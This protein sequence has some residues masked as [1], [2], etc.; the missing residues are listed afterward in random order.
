MA[1]LLAK[2]RLDISGLCLFGFLDGS[3]G[4]FFYI[5]NTFAFVVTAKC[6]SAMWAQ[7]FFALWAWVE[8]CF[9]QGKMRGASAFV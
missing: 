4:A 8:S 2:W 1:I 3:V 9:C 5:D 7:W 6:A